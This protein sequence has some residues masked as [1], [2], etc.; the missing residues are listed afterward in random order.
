MLAVA[1]L[2][3]PIGCSGGGDDPGEASSQIPFY[4]VDPD[5]TT[6]TDEAIRTAQDALRA[7][8]EDP[9]AQL[10]LAQAFLQKGRETADPTLY[11]SAEVLL[12]MV[13]EVA[14][15]DVRV[16]TAQGSLALT[17]HLFADALDLSDQA[18]EVAPGNETAYGVRVDALNEL[19]RYDEAVEATQ[20]MVD[21]RPSLA[22]LARVSYAREL[23][24]DL[25]GAILAMGQ[26]I[27][28]AAGSGGENVAFAQVQLGNLLLTRG[29]L[30]AAGQEYEEALATFPELAAARAGQARLLVAQERFA[31]AADVLAELVEERPLI[32]YAVALG[33]AR[34]AA[35]DDE[36]AEDAYAL[37]EGIARLLEANGFEVDLDLAL[38]D[39][40]RDP[41][42]GSVAQARRGLEQRPNIIGHDALAWALFTAGQPD[43]AADEVEAALDT[44]SRDP[45]IRYHAAEVAAATDDR[46]AAEEHLQVVLDTNPR[47]SAVHVDDVAALADELG[48]AVPPVPAT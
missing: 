5:S 4:E 48:L 13:A 14:P 39:A 31:E 26:A 3:V 19:G 11:T 40:E 17:R 10:D 1:L 7:D 32:E 47:F 15:D 33:D 2:V 30:V 42:E 28:A 46:A 45:Q 12:D 9:S 25:D 21:I 22:S 34:T 20:A 44:G 6:P 36:E 24:G 37:V 18:L 27:T 23:Q 8:P 29:D 41:G 43:E 35:G 16:L 38:F